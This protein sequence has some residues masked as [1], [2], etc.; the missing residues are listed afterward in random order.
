MASKTGRAKCRPRF[1]QRHREAVFRVLYARSND[2]VG[3]TKAA[4]TAIKLMDDL[5]ALRAGRATPEQLNRLINA[6]NQATILCASEIGA[7][8]RAVLL[9]ASL[10]LAQVAEHY[11]ATEQVICPDDIEAVR[12]MIGVHEGQRTAE[13][14]TKGLE[15]QARTAAKDLVNQGCHFK[16]AGEGTLP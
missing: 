8:Y 1:D 11:N 5:A 9:R 6:C 3:V 4:V 10:A 15:Y 12:E 14:F 16:V 13:G 2:S 7:E